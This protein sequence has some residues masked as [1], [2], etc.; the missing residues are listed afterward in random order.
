MERYEFKFP[1]VK[2]TCLHFCKLISE[3]VP[4]R[5]LRRCLLVLC[6]NSGLLLWILIL[7]LLQ[8]RLINH[9]RR[10]A[11]KSLIADHPEAQLLRYGF[12]FKWYFN[13][14]FQLDMLEQKTLMIRTTISIQML[15]SFDIIVAYNELFS[16]IYQYS[17]PSLEICGEQW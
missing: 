8:V 6:A 7:Y 14:K 11:P 17:F 13:C 4:L 9:Q 12:L 5:F 1:T 15:F 10:E 16:I 3:V 2:F